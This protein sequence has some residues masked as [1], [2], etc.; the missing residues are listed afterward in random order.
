M[1]T[2]PRTSGIYQILCVPTGK[3]YIGSTKNLAYRW[4]RHAQ[5]LRLQ[6]HEN[7]YLQH[8][9]NKYG[10][11]AFEFTVIELVLSSFRVE[12]EQFWL[13]KLRPY[14]RERGF[15]IS[16]KADAPMAGRKHTQESIEKMSHA[17]TGFRHTEETKRM[18]SERNKGKMFGVQ[19]EES[20]R[21]RS[22]AAKGRKRTPET[23]ERIRQIKLEKNAAVRRYVITDPSGEV[24]EIE[25]LARFCR[26]NHL[27]K[28]CMRQ[29][30]SGK[31]THHKG[32]TCRYP[33][34][35]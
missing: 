19:T 8:A 16:L 1:T 21:K 5:L 18:M 11:S 4:K 22:V 34:P 2:I 35:Q 15:N 14:D 10:A 13:D 7:S 12:R 9:W 23:I 26:E 3:V 33:F 30:V 32:W 20:R 28:D 17:S 24:Q 29:V 27:S 31:K 25:N 6:R